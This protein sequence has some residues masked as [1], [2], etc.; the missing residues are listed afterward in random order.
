MPMSALYLRLLGLLLLLLPFSTSLAD[1][2]LLSSLTSP[3]PSTE[4]TSQASNKEELEALSSP[5]NTITTFLSAMKVLKTDE[6]N[7]KAAVKQ[8]LL[9]L[10][11]SDINSIVRQERGE[12][13][14]WQLYALIHHFGEPNQKKLPRQL[15]A[16][17]WTW[18]RVGEYRISLHKHERQV[19]EHTEIRWLFTNTTLQHLEAMQA[20]LQAHPEKQAQT[21]TELQQPLYLE[22]IGR[23]PED[24]K[25]TWLG[26]KLWQWLGILGFV[27]LGV[28]LDALFNKLS[29]WI[30]RYFIKRSHR[31]AYR[32][33]SDDMLRPFGLMVMALVWWLG[34]ENLFLPEWAL[35]ILMVAV[36]FL[37]S[38]SSVWAAY[39]L[40]DLASAW[41][42][43]KA[44]LT[45]NK[46]DDALVPLARR[47]IKIF[48]TV[49]GLLF[50]ANSL[51][52]NI[53]GLLAGLGLGGLALALAAK[54]LAQNLFGT[55]TILM[56]RTFSVGDWVV[57]NDIEGTVE[58]IS[59][60][61][62]RIRT[63]YDSVI[64]LP[65]SNLITTPVDNYGERRFRR[66]STKL[67]LAYET[68]ADKVEAFCEGVREIVRL[69]K[70]MR[71]DYFHVYFNGYADSALE[72]LVYVFWQTPD[73]QTELQER[74]RFLLDILR[75]ARELDVDFAYPTQTIYWQDMQGKTPSAPE[76]MAPEATR[77]LAQQAAR[78]VVKPPQ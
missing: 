47:S 23:I 57:I 13:L 9:A 77:Q 40:V 26:L 78:Q 21:S 65:N 30:M 1:E 38:I 46:F 12:D 18:K 52:I 43:H 24:Y 48:V 67:G 29:S 16:K 35:L 58:D 8:A 22:L 3:T 64:T 39:R 76:T 63:F 74:H 70:H 75:L 59:F 53:T 14:A 73:W 45:A 41:F 33:L 42:A 27:V 28:L 34:V 37:V 61:S 11:L 49:I 60:R 10:D 69:H 17:E 36:K 55:I 66:L 5:A 51:Q 4:Q 25:V 54:D 72:I 44:S 32:K 20:W 15:K 62:T 56:E 71:H 2:G 7:D 6:G 31:T 50:I 68:P 19:G